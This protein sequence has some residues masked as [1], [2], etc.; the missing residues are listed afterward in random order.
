LKLKRRDALEISPAVG[1]LRRVIESSSPRVRIED[2]LR[3]VDRRCG[4]SRI[5][6]PLS[7][8]ESRP[9][10]IYS[11]LLALLIAHGTNLGIAAMGQK[12]AEDYRRHAAARQPVVSPGRDPQGSAAA[13]ITIISFRAARSGEAV[14]PHPLMATGSDYI[15]ARCFP[16]SILATSTITSAP[17]PSRCTSP[18]GTPSSGHA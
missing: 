2:L 4:F 6:Q 16:P 1:R 3:E 17:F 18:I 12:R 13:P 8:Y 11:T 7:G 14:L 15:K 9:D 5:F 10:N